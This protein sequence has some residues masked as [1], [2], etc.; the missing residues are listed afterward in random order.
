MAKIRFALLFLLLT[1][2]V[3]HSEQGKIKIVFCDDYYCTQMP[4]GEEYKIVKQVDWAPNRLTLSPDEKYVAYTAS[5]GLGFE[6]EGRDVFFCK[7][8]GSERIFLHKFESSM[9]TLIWAS[10]GVRDFI[11]VASWDCSLVMEE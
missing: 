6:N 1:Y 4:T 8:D 9:D 11:F 3:G 5:N 2:G 7:V 10:S